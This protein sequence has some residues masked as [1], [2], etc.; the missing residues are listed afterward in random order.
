MIVVQ[1]K[2]A[3]DPFGPVESD[4]YQ[5]RAFLQSG[6]RSRDLRTGYV[7][8]LGHKPL[9]RKDFCCHQILIC[10]TTQQFTQSNSNIRNGAILVP[11][12]GVPD[13]AVEGGLLPPLL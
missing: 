3:R 13:I 9:K 1:S 10:R 11:L 5:C 2:D 7:A 4:A 8:K 6:H 12:S